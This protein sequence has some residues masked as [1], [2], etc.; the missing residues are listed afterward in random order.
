LFIGGGIGITPLRPMIQV[1]ATRNSQWRLIYGGRT[2]ASMAFADQFIQRYPANVELHPQD[3]D[4]LL[5]LD[6]HLANLEPGTLVYCCGPEPLLNAV[7]TSCRDLPDGTLHIE[8]FLPRKDQ[9][10]DPDTSFTV[11]LARTGRTLTV[12]AHG[13]VLDTL[14]DEGIDMDYSC[15]TGVCGTCEVAILAGTPEHRDSITSTGTP[16]AEKR[17]MTCVSRART[18]KLIL[19]L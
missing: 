13:S 16:D 8:R 10:H 6:A 18:S 5:D 3:C 17:M 15:Q 4:G 11:Q 12:P 9:S 7:E 1:A 19:D 2:A 14:L